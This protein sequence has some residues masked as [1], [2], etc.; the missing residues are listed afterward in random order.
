MTTKLHIDRLVLHT[1]GLT[2]AQ[3]QA[4]ANAIGPALAAGLN[5][6]SK[7]G[8]IPHLKITL[9]ASAATSPAQIARH[10]APQLSSAPRL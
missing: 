10:L 9:P 4:T 1:H 8:H 6:T 7:P 3:A 2:T 5:P